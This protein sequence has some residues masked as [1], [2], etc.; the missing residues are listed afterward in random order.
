MSLETLEDMI[1]ANDMSSLRQVWLMHLSKDHS[2]EQ[3]M[4]ERIQRLTGAEVYVC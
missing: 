3:V 2:Q 1:R 4:K